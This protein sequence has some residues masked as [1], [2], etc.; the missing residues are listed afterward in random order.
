MRETVEA[1]DQDLKY[2]YD[3]LNQLE[4]LRIYYSTTAKQSDK[5]IVAYRNYEYAA[6]TGMRHLEK[7]QSLLSIPLP[8]KAPTAP[9]PGTSRFQPLSAPAEIEMV[10]MDMDMSDE[11]ENAAQEATRSTRQPSNVGYF[12]GLLP[13][14]KV[15]TRLIFILK[16]NLFFFKKIFLEGSNQ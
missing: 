3:L 15:L 16:F 2:E 13:E 6:Q 11:E 5:V 14:E 8:G 4:L 9:P 12:V 1:R 7:A 10:E